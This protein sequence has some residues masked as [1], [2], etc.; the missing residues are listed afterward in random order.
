MGKSYVGC[1]ASHSLPQFLT[2]T[3]ASYFLHQK[4]VFAVQN[5][6]QLSFSFLV[7]E[8]LEL[9][10]GLRKVKQGAQNREIGP[11]EAFVHRDDPG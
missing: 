10:L 9:K 6:D 8:D 1:Y 4:N 2:L 11:T 5:F 7:S 3:M